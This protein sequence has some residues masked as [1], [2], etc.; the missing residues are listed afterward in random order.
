LSL[1]IGE[2]LFSSSSKDDGLS[3]TRDSVDVAEEQLRNMDLL[4]AD[5][6][7]KKTCRECLSAGLNNWG[8]MVAK[9]AREEELRQEKA[10]TQSGVFSFWSGTPANAEDRWTA[11][12]AVVKERVRRT[13]ELIEDLTPAGPNLAS[14][15]KA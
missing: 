11:E 15:F 13:R 6:A 8:K 4:A 1:W 12:D 9:L 7:A 2:I 3:W 10:S 5:K 14:L